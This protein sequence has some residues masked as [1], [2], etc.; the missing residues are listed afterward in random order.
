LRQSAFDGPFVAPGNAWMASHR[1]SPRARSS[2]GD[3]AGDHYYPGRPR[4]RGWLAAEALTLVD[5]ATDQEDDWAY[6][7]LLLRVPAR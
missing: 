4:V 7:H 2:E 3:V 6:W 5:E 1:P